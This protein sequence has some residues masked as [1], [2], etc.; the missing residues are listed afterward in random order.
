[1]S[2][3]SSLLGIFP[4]DPPRRSCGKLTRTCTQLRLRTSLSEAASCRDA[5]EPPRRGRR[6]QLESAPADLA[7]ATR[8]D[9]REKFSAK[10]LTSWP[11]R[12]LIPRSLATLPVVGI[13]PML[14]N[15]MSKVV[16]SCPDSWAEPASSYPPSAAGSEAEPRFECSGRPG[17]SS[18]PC[19]APTRCSPRA[20]WCASPGCPSARSSTI[21]ASYTAP[22]SSTASARRVRSAP[23]HTTAG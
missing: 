5:V 15:P 6:Q 22:A 3:P 10:P 8:R 4:V 23:A 21:S 18:S 2:D 1:M 9:S 17:A 14:Q 7:P 13:Q 20:S 19:S 16:L 11:D 12:G